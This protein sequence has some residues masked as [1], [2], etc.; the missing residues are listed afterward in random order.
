MKFG[1]AGIASGCGWARLEAGAYYPS[2]V[3]AAA[4]PGNYLSVFIYDAFMGLGAEK[5]SVISVAPVSKGWLVSLH[6]AL[7]WTVAGL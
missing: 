3:L 2:D 4:A 6:M 5:D 7:P 1:F